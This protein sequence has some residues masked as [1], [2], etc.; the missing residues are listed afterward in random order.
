M[1]FADQSLSNAIPEVWS[2]KTEKVYR[3]KSV[4]RGLVSTDYQ[5]DLVVGD[6]VHV[7]RPG[8]LEMYDYTRNNPLTLQE[9]TLTDDTLVIDQQKYAY[10]GVDRLTQKQSHHKDLLALEVNEAAIAMRDTV[11]AHLLAHYTDVLPANIIGSLGAPITLTADNI[12]DYICDQGELL[13]NQNVFDGERH[14]VVPPKISNLIRKSP[15]LR[16]RGTQL[17]DEVIRNGYMGMYGGFK[18]HVTTNMAQVSGVYP[19]MFFVKEFI[20]FVE[21][22]NILEYEN[23]SGY[24]IKAAKMAKLYGSKVFNPEA[25]ALI[26]AAA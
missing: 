9:W 25:G 13:D 16:D 8:Q 7:Q 12:Y 11:D 18:I 3:N 14:M 4:M 20:Q 22:E 2:K 21:Q 5:A 10:F 23:P 19:L 6:T 1:A 15:E 17:V 26:Y 24:L